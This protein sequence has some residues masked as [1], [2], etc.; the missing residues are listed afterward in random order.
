M[1]AMV[2]LDADTG[3]VNGGVNLVPI[4]PIST[5]RPR[6]RRSSGRSAW[7]IASCPVTLTSS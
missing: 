1:V 6:A 5:I 7:V 3:P 2:L 4:E